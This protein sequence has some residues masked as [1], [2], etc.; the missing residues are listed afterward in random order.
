[1]NVVYNGVLFNISWLIIVTSESTLIG[2]ATVAVHLAIH[3]RLMGRG[4]AELKLIGIITIIGLLLDQCLFY[5]GIFL[6]NGAPA[7][8]PL[9]LSCLWPVFA[10]TLCHAFSAFS[11]RLAIASVVG[12]L[13][14]AGSYIVGT[15]LT[16]V[17][18]ASAMGGP[19]TL[20]I[21]WAVL[22]PAYLVLAA[23]LVPSAPSDDTR[24]ELQHG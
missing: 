24:G 20:A 14:G 5:A 3:F 16:D 2:L 9:W 15:R 8:A 1:M 12:A 21:L 6:V 17:D 10:T 19:L 23:R 18:F 4:W 7:L 22:F 11:S 13:S